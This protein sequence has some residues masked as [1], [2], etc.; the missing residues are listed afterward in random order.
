[1]IDLFDAKWRKN[2]SANPVKYS[3]LLIARRAIANAFST[4]LKSTIRLCEEKLDSPHSAC[5]SHM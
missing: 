1:M 2:V 4:Y 3:I 5:A